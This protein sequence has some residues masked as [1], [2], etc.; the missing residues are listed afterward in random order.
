M[1]A[2]RLI[3]TV[4]AVTALVLV[5]GACPSRTLAAGLLVPTDQSL[6]PLSVTKHAVDVQIDGLVART[7]LIQTFRNHTDRQLEATYVFPIPEG[8]DITGFS[9]TFAGKMVPGEVLPA[10]E[11]VQIYE[12][13]VRQAR[14][15]GLIEFIGRRL[16]RMRVFPIEA[17]SDTTI[18]LS[19]QQIC[20]PVATFETTSGTGLFGYHYP[21]RTTAANTASTALRFTVALKSDVALKSIWSPTHQVEVVRDG[22]HNA[23]VAFESNE[24]SLNE[25]FLLLFDREDGDMGLSALT[26]L[27][28]PDGE[29]L[30][31]GHFL[32][33]LNPKTFWE[34][35]ERIAQDVIFVMDTSG[36]MSGEKIEQ[37]REA[38]RFCLNQLDEGDRF[39]VVRFSTGFDLLFP[40][41]RVLGE[42]T[43]DKA[44]SFVK[45]FDAGGGTN[46]HDALQA[47]VKLL[48][49]EGADGRPR[50]IVFL[51]DG[52]GDR[53]RDP[54]MNMLSKAEADGIAI[55]PFGVGH[56]VNTLLLDALAT[57]YNGAPTY[58]QPGENLELVLGDFFATFS[59]PVLTNLELTLPEMGAMDVFPPTLA[60]LYHGQQVIVAGRM[61]D[62]TVGSVKLTALRRGEQVEYTW[63][64]VAFKHDGSATYVPRLWA[65]RKIGHLIDTIRRHGETKE[66]IAEVVALSQAYGIQTPYASYLVAPERMEELALALE[67][68]TLNWRGRP[69]ADGLRRREGQLLSVTRGSGV[70]APTPAEEAPATMA[71][72]EDLLD[73][74]EAEKAVTATAGRASNVV[75]R[76]QQQLRAGANIAEVGLDQRRQ[77]VQNYNGR[78]YNYIDG[79]LIDQEMTEETNVT[80]IQFG[81]EAY[82]ELARN[83]ADLR[84]ALAASLNAVVQINAAEAVAVVDGESEQLQTAFTAEQRLLLFNTPT[85]DVDEDVEVEEEG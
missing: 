24:G 79:Y 2:T 49:G 13:I 60:D 57:D 35:E 66:L 36:S 22:E 32:L 83:R 50:L 31:E 6:A 76:V 28:T 5:L 39:N 9:M 18:E 15:P 26:Y 10:D 71:A 33:L 8:A 47:A 16:L 58:V 12:Q 7:R 20:R 38:L 44:K 25:D 67:D 30:R 75:A 85:D 42:E 11:A 45:R 69:D 17:N 41:M 1:A 70:S 53:G 14:D 40:E 37:A 74:A 81:S 68:S 23:R 46:I 19:Y 48:K 3:R 62:P 80:Y 82:F 64:N 65:G 52:N 59:Q 61:S 43:L 34:D 55:F 51:T 78:A 73:F 63:E 77:I 27:G 84:P 54:V 21:L 56:D 72:G 29:G 4:L